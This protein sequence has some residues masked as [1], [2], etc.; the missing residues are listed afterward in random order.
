LLL[1]RARGELLRRERNAHWT[2][3]AAG[4]TATG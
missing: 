4:A 1:I 3:E 2:A